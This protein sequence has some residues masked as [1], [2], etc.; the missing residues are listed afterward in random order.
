[1]SEF[2]LN[3]KRAFDPNLKHLEMFK[4]SILCYLIVANFLILMFKTSILCYLIVANFLILM[5]KTSILCYLIVANFLI[6]E[7]FLKIGLR[8]EFK[9]ESIAVHGHV[10]KRLNTYLPV[11]VLA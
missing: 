4:T 10:P 8:E 1:M 2:D 6:L 7:K 3:S 9:K 11:I 5:F